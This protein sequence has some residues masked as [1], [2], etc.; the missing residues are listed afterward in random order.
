MGSSQV[1]LQGY[2]DLSVN[3]KTEKNS[4]YQNVFEFSF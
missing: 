2:Y 1:K 3:N 4:I